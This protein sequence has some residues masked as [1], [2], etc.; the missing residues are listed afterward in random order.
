MIAEADVGTRSRSRTRVKKGKRK[1][2]KASA[3]TGWC[4]GVKSNQRITWE[5]KWLHRTK[6]EE[7]QMEENR[8]LRWENDATETEDGTTRR[9]VQTRP[10]VVE[11]MEPEGRVDDP[12]EDLATPNLRQPRV[13]YNRLSN[14][15]S[16]WVVCDLGWQCV[17]PYPAVLVLASRCTRLL[18]HFQLYTAVARPRLGRDLQVILGTAHF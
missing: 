15:F 14:L 1:T 17:D 12:M 5:M 11:K 16:F 9:S 8:K 2:M 6:K 7:L 4:N 10:M 18:K 3:V 13:L